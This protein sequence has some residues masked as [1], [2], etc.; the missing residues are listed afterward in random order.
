MLSCLRTNSTTRDLA[1]GNVYIAP[2]TH[3]W[4][5]FN[6]SRT[7]TLNV[8]QGFCHRLLRN[9]TEQTVIDPLCPLFNRVARILDGLTNKR[10]LL[11]IQPSHRGG[12]EVHIQRLQLMFFVNLN[13][14]LFSPQLQ[15]EVDP[16]QDAGTWYGLTSKLVC[17]SSENPLRRTVLVPIGPIYAARLGLHVRVNLEGD[18]RYGKF[19][20]NDTL[21]RIDCAA[22]PTLVYMKALLHA[23]TSFLLPD[24]LTGRTGVEES[25]DWLR[26]GICRPWT[27]LDESSAR[28]LSQIARLTPVREYYPSDLKVMRTDHWDERLTC[29]IQHPLYQQLVKEII[30]VSRDLEMFSTAHRHIH[31]VSELPATGEPHLTARALVRRRMYERKVGNEKGKE[32]DP[33]YLSRDRSSSSE[34]RYATVMEITHLLRTTPEKFKTPPNL[35]T[36]LSQGNTIGGYGAEYGTV[37]LTEQMRTDVR[38]HWGALVESCRRSQ[39]GYS[40][41]FLL[42]TVSFRDNFDDG[43]LKGILAFATFSELQALPLPT[44]PSYFNFHPDSEPKVDFIAKLIHPFRIPAPEDD[45]EQLG[46][47][48]TAKQRRKMKVAKDVH[49]MRSE[50]DCQYLA[51]CLVAQWPC[52]E[53]DRSN[54]ART[55]LLVDITAALQVIHPEWLRLF[56]NRDLSLHLNQVQHIL[57]CRR[58]ELEYRPPTVIVSEV[59][60]ASP[61]HPAA[62]PNLHSDLLGK[63]FD[64]NAHF[65]SQSSV[66]EWAPL[67]SIPQDDRQLSM[68]V[69]NPRAT[70]NDSSALSRREAKTHIDEL[71]GII[72]QLAKSK[73]L[74]RKTYA[75]DLTQSLEAFKRLKTPQQLAT[76]L[77]LR[78]NKNDVSQFLGA[79]ACLQGSLEK[80]TPTMSDR[81]IQWL[82][83]GG[84]WPA[85]TTVSLLEPLRSTASP[86][87]GAGVR[88]ALITFGVTITNLQRAMRLNDCV[89]AGDTSRFQDE[90]ANLGHTNWKPQDHPDWLLLEIDS[91]FLIRPG[92]VDVALATISPASG[93]N[94]VLQMN[95]GQGKTSCI[96]PMVA[97]AMADK[98]SLVRIIVPKALLQQT[99]QLLQSR[100]G[101]VLN[102]QV[103][104]I[105]FSRRTATSK[106][107]IQLYY[108]I[109]W[110]TLKAAGV[111]LCLPEHNLS[112]LLG[113]QQKILDNKVSEATPMIKVQAWLSSVCRDILDESDYTLAARTQ[114]I[115]PSGSQLS[116]DGHPHRWHIAQTLLNLVDQHMYDLQNSFPQS[117]EVVRRQ[118]DGFPLIYFARRDVEDELLMRLAA[119]ISKGRGN[120]LPVDAFDSRERAAVRDFLSPS[121]RRLKPT[122]LA[123]IRTL[124]SDKPQV[125]QAVYLT[126]GLL[127]NRILIMTLKKRWNVQYGLR[128]NSDP[129]AVPYQAKGVPSE[130]SE[131]GHPDV[132]ILFTCLAFYYDGLDEKQ[133]KL[134][135]SR[136]L[137]SDDPSTEY[138]KWVHSS[139]DFPASVRAW[140]TINIEDATQVGEIWRAV[141]YQVV[142]IDY[143][144]NNFVFPQHAKQFTAKLQS[145]GWDVPLFS[146]Q[147]D[148]DIKGLGKPQPR[149]LTT[150]FSG[151]NDNR[152]MLPLTIQQADLPTLSHTNAEVLTYLLHDRSRR[153]ETIT[154]VRG[155]RATERDLLFMLKIKGIR[156]LIDA[157]AQILEMDNKTLAKTW[158][159]IDKGCEAALYFDSGNKPWVISKL[160]RETPLLASPYADDLS[161]CLVYLDEA[162]T[163]GTDLKFPPGARGALTLGQGQSKDHTV[164]GEFPQYHI[165]SLSGANIA[166]C[167]ATPPAGND[168]VNHL[169]HP[170]RGAPSNS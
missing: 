12:L 35:S 106:A 81:R 129:V 73:S 69:R 92:Q 132:A 97:A 17:C 163:R 100:L 47:L 14:R 156:I 37:S 141:R 159:D 53:P 1:T 127:V 121:A 146:A 103:G 170:P 84:L 154:D 23:Y 130:Q 86:S 137:K 90:E 46:M 30:G 142:V 151:T 45:G 118:G 56:Q 79:F 149:A 75:Q 143:F 52:R 55:D 7:W 112:F 85:I 51:K 21:G 26:S 29:H 74:V 89:R 43:L 140:N 93:T 27:V 63:P 117:L 60:F 164:Q 157:G 116:V 68:H 33:L 107:S 161:K 77:G 71:Q 155:D 125:R 96:I 168:A 10:Q 18:G 122:T 119:D 102:R 28:V 39:P 38:E 138:D 124:C 32:T 59:V 158:L 65:W 94:S 82:K 108:D 98:K 165:F 61:R 99:A 24:P 15:L 169:L 110:R 104:H 3:P 16:N 152:T 50:Q 4:D 41:M 150:G 67:A 5:I 111:M 160:G 126:R 166:S 66:M 40:L 120:M 145:S 135:L 20:I 128:P 11:V 167:H 36:L 9:E 134:A 70:P 109:H 57:N 22:E 162:H 78:D 123:R 8:H 31:G 133:L 136:V 58:S 147:S 64:P 153:C 49:E 48:I 80:A 115:Y 139:D 44:W 19:T 34:L 114:L 101:R 91:N 72:N 62:V 105:P 54:V 95:M 76:F 88:D 13:K 42:A 25:L 131:W 148:P 2:I 6:P 83:M 113:G 87:F 144:L